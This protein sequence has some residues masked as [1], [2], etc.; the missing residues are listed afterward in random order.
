VVSAGESLSSVEASQPTPAAERAAEPV[1]ST[2]SAASVAP[3]EPAPPARAIRSEW[4]ELLAAGQLREGLRAAERADFARVCETATLKELLALADA[5]RFFG[6]TR[7]A[8]D[9]LT[10][11]RRRFPHSSDAG[12][13]AFTLGR[14]ALEKQG[15]YTTAASWFEV[16]LREQPNG[17]LMGDAFGRLM[18][19]RLRSGDRAGARS[20]AE[21]Y[22]RRFPA[23]P[24]AQEARDILAQ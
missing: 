9:A 22:L 1:P 12:T 6:P 13:A 8:T 11:L 19:A 10:S 23:G 15:A 21:Q 16:Y 3:P 5:G 17:A 18:E 14:I 4:Q 20:S 2:P 7:R 24:Y